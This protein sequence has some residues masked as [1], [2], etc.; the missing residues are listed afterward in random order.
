MNIYKLLIKNNL[1]YRLLH[2]H[3]CFYRISGALEKD[4]MIY[5]Q[6]KVFRATYEL[7]IKIK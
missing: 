2:Y 1:N 4:T 3:H 6:T 7:V 5:I